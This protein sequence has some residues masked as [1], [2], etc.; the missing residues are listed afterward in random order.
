MAFWKKQTFFISKE[1][2]IFL[3]GTAELSLSRLE[4]EPLPHLEKYDL[5]VLAS[6]LFEWGLAN[7]M[8]LHNKIA[9]ATPRYVWM[10]HSENIMILS[11]V[12]TCKSAKEYFSVT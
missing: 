6:S 12:V 2:S 7:D 8:L 5:D 3:I 4:D 9:D 1:A 10:R 11:R